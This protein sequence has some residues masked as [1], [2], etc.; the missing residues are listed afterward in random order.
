M[1]FRVL[2]RDTTP[3]VQRFRGGLV[4]KAHRLLYHSPLGLR[5]IKRERDGRTFLRRRREEYHAVAVV[6]ELGRVRVD[7][8]HPVR[9]NP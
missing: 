1:G 9:L 2:G 5:V 7:V 4:C 8:A 6:A 3:N